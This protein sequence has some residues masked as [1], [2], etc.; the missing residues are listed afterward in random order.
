[1]YRYIRLLSDKKVDPLPP[2]IEPKHIT[3]TKDQLFVKMPNLQAKKNWTRTAI[4]PCTCPRH[5]MMFGLT[6]KIH[7]ERLLRDLR[8]SD[9]KKT[10]KTIIWIILPVAKSDKGYQKYY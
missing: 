1:M 6:E 4:I 9:M 10:L 3:A 7:D 5:Q 2:D 8:V